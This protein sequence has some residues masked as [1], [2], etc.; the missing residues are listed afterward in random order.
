T[1][2]STW[3]AQRLVS[4]ACR[5]TWALPCPAG[6]SAGDVRAGATGEFGR[7]Q[8][9]GGG[10]KGRFLICSR[11]SGCGSDRAAAM[12]ILRLSLVGVAVSAILGLGVG[13]AAQER[14]SAGRERIDKLFADG[15]FKSALEA[16]RRLA[17]DPKTEPDRV[18]TD[19][20]Q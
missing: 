15:N 20:K 17:L 9:S 14:Q 16:Y 8:A 6:S 19:L 7:D 11:V 1:N 5:D 18:G 10:L 3:Q 4:T 2:A 13:T 12:V